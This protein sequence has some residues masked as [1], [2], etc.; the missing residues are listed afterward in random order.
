MSASNRYAHGLLKVCEHRL[1]NGCVHAWVSRQEAL[2][3]SLWRKR[4]RSAH[5]KYPTRMDG[6]ICAKRNP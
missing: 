1:L 6:Q 4:I 3:H 5:K 2:N